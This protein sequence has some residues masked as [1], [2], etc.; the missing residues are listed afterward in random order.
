MLMFDTK[1]QNSVKQLPFKKL[2]EKKKKILLDMKK[3]IGK[4]SAATLKNTAVA[5]IFRIG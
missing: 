4:E 5:S 3:F 1:Q 2:T